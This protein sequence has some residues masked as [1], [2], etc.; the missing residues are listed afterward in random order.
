MFKLDI[1]KCNNDKLFASNI[2]I[3]SVKSRVFH[4]CEQIT[5]DYKLSVFFS[6]KTNMV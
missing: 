3:A 1:F 6:L 5:M 4:V 2:F